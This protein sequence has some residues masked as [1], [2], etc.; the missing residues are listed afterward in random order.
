[1]V[2]KKEPK[3]LKV[4]DIWFHPVAGPGRPFVVRR[5]KGKWCWSDNLDDGAT[6]MRWPT[7]D[8]A[9]MERLD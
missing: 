9:R 5:I 6:N 2:K 4:G 8:V 7:A 3:P 1:M